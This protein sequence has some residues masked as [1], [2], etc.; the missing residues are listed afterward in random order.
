MAPL[1]GP[2][3][4]FL[5]SGLL[6]DLESPFAQVFELQWAQLKEVWWFGRLA[7]SNYK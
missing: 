1:R 5:T 4:L 6:E 7:V 3:L 2:E